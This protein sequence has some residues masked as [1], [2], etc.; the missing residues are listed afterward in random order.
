LG[1]GRRPQCWQDAAAGSR[2]CPPSIGYNEVKN[3]PSGAIESV[4]GRANDLHVFP[5]KGPVVASGTSA[6]AAAT[7]ATTT[8]TTTTTTAFPLGFLSLAALLFF[9]LGLCGAFDVA[10]FTAVAIIARMLSMG[11]L[12]LLILWAVFTTSTA[13]AYDTFV[14]FVFRR[15]HRKVEGRLRSLHDFIFT[16]VIVFGLAQ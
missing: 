4:F 3:T 7:T 14:I 1:R 12:I 11:F 5:N 2:G 8:T 16:A 13:A 10:P 6:G 15:R 9:R